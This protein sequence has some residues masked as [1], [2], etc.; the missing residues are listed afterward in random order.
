VHLTQRGGAASEDPARCVL[1]SRVSAIESVLPYRASHVKE[2]CRIQYQGVLIEVSARADDS[3]ATGC[4]L[5]KRTPKFRWPQR[6]EAAGM[7]RKQSRPVVE[8]SYL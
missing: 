4:S 5:K 8:A 2:L 3:S 6:K 7:L 1:V